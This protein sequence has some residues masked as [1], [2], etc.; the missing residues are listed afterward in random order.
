MISRR[1]LISGLPVGLAA[2][3][4]PAK[5]ASTRPNFIIIVSDDHEHLGQSVAYARVNGIVPPWTADQMK[6]PPAKIQ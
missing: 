2:L 3:Q 5:A 1:D 6:K 4:Q